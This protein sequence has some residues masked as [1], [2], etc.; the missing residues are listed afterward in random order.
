[1]A[2]GPLI[3]IYVKGALRFCSSTMTHIFAHSALLSLYDIYLTRDLGISS[4]L[5]DIAQVTRQSKK[6]ETVSPVVFI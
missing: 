3:E 1:M 5:Y 4:E 2:A 6:E